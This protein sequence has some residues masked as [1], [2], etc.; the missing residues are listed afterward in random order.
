MGLVYKRLGKTIFTLHVLSIGSIVPFANAQEPE[1]AE[2]RAMVPSLSAELQYDD[3]IFLSEAD[4]QSSLITI[5]SPGVLTTFRPSKHRIVLRYNGEFASF[6]NSSA[7]NYDDHEFQAAAFL[8]LGVRGL[9]DIIGGYQRGHESRGSGLS[10]GL[11]PESTNFPAEPDEF[12][13]KQLSGRFSYGASG[14]KGRLVFDAGRREL[15]YKNNRDRTR[16]F[17][18]DNVHGGTTFYIRVMPSTSLLMSLRVDDFDYPNKRSFQPSLNSRE[19]RYLVG[20]TWTVTGKSTGTARFGYVEKRFDDAGR[21]DFSETSWD[22]DVRWSLR[23]YSHFDF[24]TSRYPSEATSITGDVI[25]NTRHSVAWSHHWNSR[26][27]T[28]LETQ[29]FRQDFRGSVAA[30]EGRFNRHGLTLAYEMRRWLTWEFGASFSSNDSNI[31]QYD[32]NA[33]NFRLGA[34]MGF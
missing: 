17:D 24:A 9:L 28:R 16:F 8:E 26:V 27:M 19:H 10:E 14:A 31:E 29:Y 32:Y 11:D 20:A 2:H 18:Y 30:R 4:E 34:N 33:S 15:E 3:N 13:Q 12:S 22:V 21:R 1:S 7:D 6:A 5:L 23:N 25:E